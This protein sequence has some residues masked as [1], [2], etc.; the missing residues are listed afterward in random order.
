MMLQKTTTQAAVPKNTPKSI[1]EIADSVFGD[2]ELLPLTTFETKTGISREIV[3]GLVGDGLLDVF[4]YQ[5]NTYRK[6]IVAKT[7]FV[8]FLKK[9]SLRIVN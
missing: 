2:K 5:P 3:L 6:I 8:R 4:Q 1:Q 7:S 9:T